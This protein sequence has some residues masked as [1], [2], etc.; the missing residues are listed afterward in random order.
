MASSQTFDF[1][2]LVAEVVVCWAGTVLSLELVLMFGSGRLRGGW[3]VLGL[4]IGLSWVPEAAADRFHLKSGDVIDGEV[5]Q[6]T[7]N[8]I[9]FHTGG[10]V[11]PI[12]ISQIERVELSLEDGSE[13]SGEMS[14]WTDGVYE[15]RSADVLM[16]IKDGVVIDDKVNVATSSEEETES[17]SSPELPKAK[18][19]IALAMQSLPELILTDGEILVG[20]IIHATGSIVTI[21]SQKG[22]VVPTS[23]AKIETVRF[24][25]KDGDVVDGQF[26]DWSDNIYQ[27]KNGDL[28]ILASLDDSEATT[29][30]LRSLQAQ[31]A[32]LPSEE[33]PAAEIEAADAAISPSSEPPT[34]QPNGV[35]LNEQPDEPVTEEATAEAEGASDVA[36]ITELDETTGAGGPV[37]ETSVAALT[38]PEETATESQEANRANIG[39]PR[40]VEPTV[41][42][43]DEDGDAV[44]FEFRL[45]KPAERPLV[46]LYAA[47]DDTARA[48]QDFEAKSGVITFSAGSE[49]AEVRVPLIDDEQSETNEQFHLFL[50]GDPE[51]VQ[52]SQRQI[53]ATINDND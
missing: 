15:I 7:R 43:V 14:G 40:L 49:Y 5:I 16:R 48:G 27:L 22:G 53:P 10:T 51:I 24:L 50:S 28:D 52:F 31:Q 25:G 23:R 17:A 32:T 39:G 42:D 1:C 3:G 6:A 37:S 11:L 19:S 46:I 38:E 33:P 4:A 9:T 41:K 26:V 47:T 21:R 29:T 13:L 45:D 30:R 44:V 36:E 20:T 8:T 34:D 2:L 12:S 18:P 35:A